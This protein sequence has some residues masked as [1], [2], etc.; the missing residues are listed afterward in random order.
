M[1]RRL[2]LFRFRRK[3]VPPHERGAVAA[4]ELW[5]SNGEKLQIRVQDIE[6][7]LAALKARTGRFSEEFSALTGPALGLVKVDAIVAVLVR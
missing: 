7:E 3:A 5:L 4:L 2:R 1:R 6:A